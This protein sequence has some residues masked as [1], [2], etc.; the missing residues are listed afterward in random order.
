DHARRRGH[1]EPPAL[2]ARREH[3]LPGLRA[4]P[5]HERRRERRLRPEG[6]GRRARGAQTPGRRGARH[7]AAAGLRR[8]QAR[9]ALRRAA[10]A[11]RAR[12]V[13]CQPAEGA[14]PG[15]A[16]RR[17]RPEAPPGDAGL[18]QVA[19]ARARHDLPLRHARPGGGPDDERS[20]RRLQRRPDRAD[21]L[22]RRGVLTA[23][24]RVRRGL[25]RHVEHRP[26]RRPPPLDPARADPAER[27]RHARDG[28]RRRLRRRV[29]TDPHRHRC[30]RPADRRASERRLADRAG[31]ARPRRLERRRRVRASDPP[32][33][34]RPGGQMKKSVWALAAIVAAVLAF[35]AAGVTK[36]SG[37][38]LNMIAW[39]GYLQP[40]WVKPFEKQ[41]GCTVK[42][43]YAGSSDEMVTLMRTGGGSQY[44]MVSASGDA[45]LRL[46]YGKDV[47]AIDPSKVPD[48]KNFGR[49]FQSPPN[50]TVPDNPI[51]IADAALYLMKTQPSL[52][53]RDPYELNSKQFEATI[54]LLK[55]QKP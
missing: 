20:R 53:I 18:P 51:Q 49:T 37:G 9:A 50:N 26:A 35:P 48:F 32:P 55:K 47:Q 36:G 3:G 41:S 40:D 34:P 2:R 31:H 17:A 52:G 45:S 24:D 5:A 54:N 12:A 29:H 39:E 30:R 25:R 13:D 44:D 33:H 4:F 27:R 21:R 42:P 14:A 16:A 6:E 11:R 38:T 23:C 10:A 46:I 7:G 22:A 15:R 28:R 1:H 19:A 8:P 43:K